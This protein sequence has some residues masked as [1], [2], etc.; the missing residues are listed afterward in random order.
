MVEI[1]NSSTIGLMV[2]EICNSGTIGLM[3]AE[4]CNSGTTRLTVVEICNSGT[5]GPTVAELCNSGTTGLTMVEIC[6]SGTSR[7]SSLG[8][9]SVRVVPSASSEGTRSEVPEASVSGSS[10]SGIPSSVDVK[11][12]SDLEVMKSCHDVD[13][14]IKDESLGSIRE[15][16]SIP[17]EYD[18]H[19]S[20]PKQRPYNPESSEISISNSPPE[21]EK[22]RVETTPKR[23]AGS[24][25]PEQA[26]TARLGKQIKIAVKKHKSRHDEGSSRAISRGEEPMASIEGDSSPTYHRP[27]IMKDL[28]ET[29]V[30]KDDEGYYILQMANWAPKDLTAMMQARWLNLSY[31]S[32]V[33]DDSQA[34][35][36]FGRGGFALDPN[37]GSLH[38]ALQDLYGKSNQT[39]HVGKLSLRGHH[40]HITLL[41]RVHDVGHLVTIMGN[42][43]SLLEVEIDKLKT[44]GDPEQLA[45]AQ[46]QVAEL[47]ADNAKMRLELEELARRSD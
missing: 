23:P 7:M 41:D 16:Y 28:C 29:R 38:L 4:I 36:E 1:C 10:S 47:Q 5:I 9:S 8:S 43:A 45:A 6:N 31:M 26:A 2:A 13:S 34:A 39:N 27:K 18:L 15:C 44:E 11:S 35:S 42:R 21:V 33:W 20:L 17:K 12:L 46:Q 3:V 14:V 30:R 19:A 32:K 24:L 22:V 37:K 25:A 40:Y